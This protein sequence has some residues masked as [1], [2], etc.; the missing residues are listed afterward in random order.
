MRASARVHFTLHGD[1][2]TPRRPNTPTPHHGP[3][4]KQPQRCKNHVLDAIPPDSGHCSFLLRFAVGEQVN[5]IVHGLHRHRF[6]NTTLT[7]AAPCSLQPP[8]GSL[9]TQLTLV[10]VAANGYAGY[11]YVSTVSHNPDPT[12][13]TL[14]R[15][16]MKASWFFGWGAAFG[17]VVY[18]RECCEKPRGNR[19]M[20]PLKEEAEGVR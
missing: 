4:A 6:G 19:A 5:E 17:A 9:C 11:H 14:G 20:M 1:E 13:S 12:V 2:L 8:Q 3:R 15:D 16:I 10:A 7:A 18:A